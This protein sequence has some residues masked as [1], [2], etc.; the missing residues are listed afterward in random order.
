ML[1]FGAGPSAPA[2]DISKCSQNLGGW[3]WT[4]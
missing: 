2:I 4:I 1:K 3:K